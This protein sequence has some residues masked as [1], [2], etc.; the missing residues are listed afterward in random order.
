MNLLERLNAKEFKSKTFLLVDMYV[1]HWQEHLKETLKPL[2]AAY[3]CGL[4][5]G[6]LEYAVFAIFVRSYHSYLLGRELVQLE[7]E[8]AKY[9]EAIAKF[10]QEQP[11]YLNQMYRQAVLNLM[12]QSE[13]PCC[14]RGESY[15]EEKNLPLHLAIPDNYTI[16]HLYFNKFLLCYLF[17]HYSEA[18]IY[19]TKAAELLLDGAIGILVVPVFYFYDSLARIA[20][21]FD[22]SHTEQQRILR[23][24]GINQKK[25]EGWAHHAPMNYWHKFY[26]V[27]AERY[28]VLGRDVLAM[29]YYD[30]SIALAQ[31]NEYL[32]EEALAHELAGK[33]YLAKDKTRIART[34]LLDAR[35]YYQQWGATAKVKD[36]EERYPQLLGSV[37]EQIRIRTTQ[38][39]TSPTTSSTT[40]TEA[41]DLATVMKA[42]QALSREMVLDKLLAKLMEIMIE[43]AGA[44]KG[45]LILET[46]GKMLIE[47]EGAVNGDSV[48][49]LQSIPIEGQDAEC[50]LSTAIIN[51]VAHSRESVVLT[52]A[53]QDGK[54]NQDSYIV[55]HQP[56][57]ILCTPLV[58]RG[59]L[60]GIVYLENNLT[61][62]AFTA[63]RLEV[64]Q[65]LSATAA[66]AID[67][68]RLYNELELRVQ[69]R[70]QELTQANK[71]LEQL[72]AEL[73]SS[74]QELE[75]F[76][77]IASHDLQEPLRA[78]ANYTQM[79]AKRY[80]GKLDEKADIYIGF[81][82]DGATRMQQL[83]KDLL[84]Y[85]RVGR[86]PLKWQATDCNVLVNKVLRDL[87]FSIAENEANITVNSLPTLWAD[88]TQITLLFQNLIG[89]AIKYRSEAPPQVDISAEQRDSRWLFRI[90][91]NGI[92]IEPEYA[93]QIFGIFQRLHTHDEYPGT[94]LGLAICQKIV[95]RHGGSIWVESQL[96]KGSLFCFEIPLHN[97]ETLHE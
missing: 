46:K 4:E 71:Q 21:F 63:E 83:I 26:L 95:E 79:L 58:D 13:N 7:Q 80:R 54:F 12:G 8:M 76:A 41:L 91:D 27:E 56:K 61:T 32:N 77:Y 45:F 37:S 50:R 68:A 73:K 48:T 43:N 5:T 6:D 65:M 24:V 86:Q 14:L 57:S 29:D 84:A 9:G 67:N 90:R 87:Q 42:S 53:T 66:I 60:T 35:Y 82:V 18:V 31:E 11:L 89:N 69:E 20:V 17:E 36:L 78:V 74:N 97:G 62:A 34:Y 16:Y 92:G 2:L 39:A 23:K 70:T 19:G 49:L 33:F 22:S 52:D 38:S 55:N 93:E 94:G 44:E 28:R 72:T 15:N 3:Q 88:T 40:G 81:A 1:K 75:Q 30:K 10:K 51:Y 25:M 96:A 47:A 85:S 64:L 59:K